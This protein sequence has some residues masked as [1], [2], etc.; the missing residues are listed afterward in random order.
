MTENATPLRKP[1]GAVLAAI[2]ILR[3]LDAARG[4]AGVNQIARGANV[5]PSTC[6]NILRTLAHERLVTFDPTT[7]TYELGFGLAALAKSALEQGSL[8]K[9]VR[10]HLERL[11]RQ[12]EVTTTLWYRIG[13]D[14]VMLVDSAE[15]GGAIRIRMNVGQRLPLLV[16]A[17]GRCMAAS[18]GLSKA[19]LER[20]F[21]SLR[22]ATPMAFNSYYKQVQAAR[23]DGFA[24]DR[25][26][27]AK[28]IT[29]ASSAV[30]AP[31]GRPIMAISAV[32][33]SA[34][35]QG[36]SLKQLC[37]AIRDS[38]AEI[39]SALNSTSLRT[40]SATANRP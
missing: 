26:N 15:S 32:T 2:R 35:I 29:T 30:L 16:G 36:K 14:R 28:G 3:F 39:T 37:I 11:A 38:A 6:F 21:R 10:P 7:K 33:F 9:L 40:G 1:V 20:R 23:A 24:V 8:V 17:F 13:D 19:A 25:E 27:F 5:I 22:W 31:D 34:Q 12:H 4:P 18:E